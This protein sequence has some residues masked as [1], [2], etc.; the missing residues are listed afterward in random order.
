MAENFKQ[1]L[2]DSLR[3]SYNNMVSFDAPE[4]SDLVDLAQDVGYGFLPVIGTALATRDYERAR[5]ENDYL[6]MGL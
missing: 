3:N 4:N 5:R 2:I 6:G 1:A